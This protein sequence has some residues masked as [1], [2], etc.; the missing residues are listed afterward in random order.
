MAEVFRHSLRVYDVTGQSS[1]AHVEY[2]SIPAGNVLYE[3]NIALIG[4]SI[5]GPSGPL[6]PACG[7]LTQPR[8]IANAER[9][10]IRITPLSPESQ[11]LWGFV[12]FTNN[13][14]QE[15]TVISPQQ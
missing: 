9:V 5:R 14:S 11:E 3:T 2:L 7:S 10:R 6:Y 4:Q 15:V 1:V 12:S 8:E 13:E